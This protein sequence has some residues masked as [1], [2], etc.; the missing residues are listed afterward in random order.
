MN[1]AILGITKQIIRDYLIRPAEY[2]ES[3]SGFLHLIV[4]RSHGWRILWTK[5][6]TSEHV[7]T[8]TL[9]NKDVEEEMGLDFLMF[10]EILKRKKVD[11][12]CVTNP[13]DQD[14]EYYFTSK[15]GAVSAIS[16][17]INGIGYFRM[18]AA[19]SKE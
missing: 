7:V 3:S 1:L 5:Q 10:E 19:K 13:M 6:V 11:F 2:N 17:V 18:Q 12:V 16:G 4:P 8:K 9:S 14:Q 15:D